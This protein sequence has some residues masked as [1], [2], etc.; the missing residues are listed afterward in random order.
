LK[1]GAA[2]ACP[3]RHP[4]GVS[5]ARACQNPS[6]GS[7][8]AENRRLSGE[9]RL[10]RKAA[11]AMYEVPVMS[12][13]ALSLSP[14]YFEEMNSSIY[15][16]TKTWFS[17]K[18]RQE[19]YD[20]YLRACYVYGRM[21][22]CMT[23]VMPW[24]TAAIPNFRDL[25]VLEVGC[26]NGAST[27]PIALN[28][29]AVRAFDI[30]ENAVEVAAQRCRLLGVSN[31]EIFVRDTC[32]IDAYLDTPQTLSKTPPDVVFCYAL[33]EH[34]TPIERIKFLKAIW[35]DLKVGGHL[36][37][38]ECPNRLHWFDWHSSMLPFADWLPEDIALLWYS[39]SD[40]SSIWPQ[41]KPKSFSELQSMDRSQLYRFG[42]G[43]SF[44][45]FAVGIGLNH[46]KV[47]AGPRSPNAIWRGNMPGYDEYW[48]K[49]LTEKLQAM[50]PPIDPAFAACCL[51][52][53]ITKTE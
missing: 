11:L 5:A 41:L 8:L 25:T 53:I 17:E 19:G 14:L 9:C 34:L 12:P 24:V 47:T 27:V 48:E 45:E 42:R 28:A 36:I 15:E 43:A 40:R 35:A 30:D 52:L 7:R 50:T 46:F 1:R 38:V 22:Q 44:H 39:Q 20:T 18:E 21:D 6:V 4:L 2:S 26:G 29:K 33:I 13:W 51:D 31:V 10:R 37:V 16:L 49:M 3:Q 23:C 32:W